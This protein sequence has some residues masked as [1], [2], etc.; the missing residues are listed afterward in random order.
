[1]SVAWRTLILAAS[2]IRVAADTAAAQSSASGTFEFWICRGACRSSDAPSVFAR[3]VLV[4]FPDSISRDSVPNRRSAQVTGGA[5]N[6]CFV[7][8]NQRRTDA[9]SYAGIETR[10]VTG[11]T[12]TQGDSLALSLYRSPDAFYTIRLGKAAGGFFGAGHSSGAGAADIR[13]PD[14][15]V[16]LRRTGS[17]SYAACQQEPGQR[18][19]R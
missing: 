3:G 19:W 17:A 14:D 7:F 9:E 5:P 10:A 11:W 2:L 4:L 12:L 18:R 6:A 8:L 13:V 16:G 15:S 1:M